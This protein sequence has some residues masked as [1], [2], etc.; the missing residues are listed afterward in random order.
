MSFLTM[1]RPHLAIRLESFGLPLRRALLE[2]SKLGVRGVQFDAVG[3]LGPRQL[4]QTARREMRH[5]LRSHDLELSALCCPLRRGLDD[6]EDLE[7]RLDH[8]RQVMTLSYDLG[9]RLATV[10][11]GEVPQDE[12]DPRRVFLTESL[13]NLGQHGDR[14][15]AV[16][17]LV[18]GREPPA[19]L[20][21]FLDRF[22]TGSLAVTYD[23]GNL[24]AHGHDPYEGARHLHRRIA[25]I[26]ATDARRSGPR[27]NAEEVQLGA[28]DVD[29]MQ[30]AA[31]LEEIEY[32]GWVAVVRVADIPS[33]VGFLR[34]FIGPH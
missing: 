28:G 5:L 15:G 23:P 2:A 4:S 19:L 14:T 12:N 33:G 10:D 9:C 17:S 18:G 3:E 26:H 30:F 1:N 16:L 8:V 24:L 34:R 32:R 27:R 29:W 6:P 7:P 20:T 21:S 25:Y 13:T 11:P 22:D 31:L